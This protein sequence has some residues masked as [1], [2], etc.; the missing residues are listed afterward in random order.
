MLER[1]PQFVDEIVIVDGNSTDRTVEVARM[2]RPD[3]VVVGQDRPGKGA[4]LRAGFA[5]A[6]GDIVVML[7]ADGSMDPAEMGGFIDQIA[8]GCDLV[9]G[10]RFLPGGGTADISLLRRFGNGGLLLVANLLYGTRFSELCYG[11]R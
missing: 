3:V 4:A 5:A 10:S 9:K 1:I 6:R 7:D 8:A 11:N 2:I